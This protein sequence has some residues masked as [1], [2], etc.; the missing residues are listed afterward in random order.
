M[1]RA[2]IAMRIIMSLLQM[3]KVQSLSLML[4]NLIWKSKSFQLEF[5]VPSVLPFH[6]KMQIKQQEL[7]PKITIAVLKKKNNLR[8][9]MK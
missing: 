5:S 7:S 9:G 8:Y 6:R 4:L 2:L 3:G 1:L